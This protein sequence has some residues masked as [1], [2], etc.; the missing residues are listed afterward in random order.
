[1]K[2]IFDFL[3]IVLFFVAYKVAGI[4]AATAVAMAASIAQITWLWWR[5]RTIDT[6][7][8]IT[9]LL[10]MVLGSATLLLKNP[11]FI[12][13]KPTAVYWMFAFAFWISH[14]VGKQPI[15][16]RMMAK[17]MTLPKRTWRA[18]SWS[19]I[20]F[21]SFA[22]LANIMVAY[23]FSENTWVNFKLFGLLGATLVFVLLQALFLS[24]HLKNEGDVATDQV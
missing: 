9:L 14:L 20:A 8:V 16:K 5:Q 2:L 17:Q 11:V 13:W 19:W 6:M 4:Y 23:R 10:I 18:L 15:I 21:F 12:K 3:P 24:K 7:Q 1:M 22:G